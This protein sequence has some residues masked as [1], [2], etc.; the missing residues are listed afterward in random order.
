MSW[1]YRV[2]TYLSAYEDKGENIRMF[3][4]CEVYYDEKGNPN[5]YSQPDKNILS[6]C[7]NRMELVESLKLIQPAFEK[8]VL[9]LDNWPK[10]WEDEEEKKTISGND[11][12]HHTFNYM[13][14]ICRIQRD[15]IQ[16]A[17]KN[18]VLDLDNC[19]KEQKDKEKKKNV[20]DNDYVCHTFNY[21]CPIC[22]T[23]WDYEDGG[24]PNNCKET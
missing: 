13:S 22:Q 8:P 19:S 12:T 18:L 23:G 2:C 1:N 5:G 17:F 7:E 24:C 10:E 21:I 15:L 6:D 3:S 20:P 11:Y 14:S 4:V 16:P 9:D